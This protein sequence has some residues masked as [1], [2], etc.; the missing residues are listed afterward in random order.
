MKQMRKL[1]LM[2][3]VALLWHAGVMAQEPLF[4]YPV[5]PDTCSTLES[6]CDYIVTNFWENYDLTKPIKDEE[7]FAKAFEDYV[8]FFKYANR[9]I[10]LSA[11]RSLMFKAQSNASNF[12]KIG[13]LAERALYGENAVYWS[14]EAYLPFAEAMAGSKQ[15]KK[16]IRNHYSAQVEKIKRNELGATMPQIEWTDAGG[17]RR[18]LAEVKATGLVIVLLTDGGMDS[19]MARLRLSTDVV[20]ND[21][22]SQ[23]EV[24]IVDITMGKA[25][26]AWMNKAKTY[27]ENWLVGASSDLNKTLD[28]RFVPSAY[29]VDPQGK[30]LNKNVSVES[31][32]RAFGN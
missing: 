2:V 17:N 22:I 21:M 3:A 10:V 9:T 29:I 16:D 15:M 30:I 14:D 13:A 12:A 24:A 25:D 32:K 8:D 5:A 1:L 23:G 18:K 20:I 11:I 4:K 19:D 31:I 6:R 28:V 27:P 26:G 7:R